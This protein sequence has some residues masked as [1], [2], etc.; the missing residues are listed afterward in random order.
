M[1]QKHILFPCL[2]FFGVFLATA[3]LTHAKVKG[4]G[5]IRTET[6][7]LEPFSEISFGGSA[8]II[9]TIGEKPQIQIETYENLLPILVTEVRKNRLKI[10][11]AEKVS[12]KKDLKL[13][14]TAPALRKL[15]FSGAVEIVSDGVLIC[16]D[17]I[18]VISGAGDAN[19][20][21]ET[22]SLKTTVSGSCDLV[23]RGS[24]QSHTIFLSGAGDIDAGDLFT[25]E[26]V[27]QISGA[28]DAIIHAEKILRVNIS[29]SSDIRYS[30]SPEISQKVSGHG[31]V[32]PL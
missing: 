2:F 26:S 32:S 23:Y 30:G 16:E 6:R 25:E 28:G 29:G 8:E 14:I 31:S 20:E 15:E 24:A 10:K 18:L 17:L 3:P 9:L 21:I 27:V 4:Q 19:L 22:Q 11:F 5:K 1:K 13:H 12:Y 7:S